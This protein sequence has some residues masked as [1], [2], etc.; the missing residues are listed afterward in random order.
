MTTLIM[1]VMKI[2]SPVKSPANFNT[3]LKDPGLCAAELLFIG[4]TSSL[5][6]TGYNKEYLIP[7]FPLNSVPSQKNFKSN[8]ALV[9]I[10]FHKRAL[11]SLFEVMIKGGNTCIGEGTK[12]NAS[13]FPG[14]AL[15]LWPVPSCPPWFPTLLF[16]WLR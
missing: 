12:L 6:Y 2:K 15:S 1:V 11:L 7:N 10:C 16:K 14:A 5:T 8:W 3:S 13:G 9:S 4:H